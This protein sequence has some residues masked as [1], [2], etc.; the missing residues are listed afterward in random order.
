[1]FQRELIALCPKNHMKHKNAPSGM[2]VEF[3]NVKTGLNVSSTETV[4]LLTHLSF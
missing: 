4:Y 2:Y 1:M 3:L